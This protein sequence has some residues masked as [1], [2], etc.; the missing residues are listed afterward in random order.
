MSEHNVSVQ[1]GESVRLLTAGKYCDRDIVVT[2]GGAIDGQADALLDGTLTT[3]NSNVSYIRGYSCR[4]STALTSVNL[5]E[6]TEIG[7][8]AFTGCSELTSFSAPKVKKI[9]SYAFSS[10]SKVKELLF[11]NAN[12]LTTYCFNGCTAL[13][14]ADVGSASTIPNYAFGNCTNLDTV[15][16]RKTDGM[17]TLQSSAFYGAN[18]TG[19][20]YVPTALVDSYKTAT[21]WS[22]HASRIRAIEDYPDIC[23]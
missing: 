20:I 13:S 18:F 16:V 10:C 5:P 3:L 15:I 4:A 22:A 21:N 8:Y 6:V 2:S 14:K 12:V 17:A 23:G 9:N 7:T 19:Y 1:P 11:P